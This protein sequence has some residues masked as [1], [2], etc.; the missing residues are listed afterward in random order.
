MALSGKDF[1]PKDV[2]F[3]GN[4]KL[5]A[6]GHFSNVHFFESSRYITVLIFAPAG[7]FYFCKKR[8]FVDG[9]RQLQQNETEMIW[10]TGDSSTDNTHTFDFT[11]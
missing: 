10:G 4:E 9:T 5:R 1:Y 3:P 8:H 11:L 6:S 7:I 2:S